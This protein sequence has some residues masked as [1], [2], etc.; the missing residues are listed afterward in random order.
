MPLTQF[1]LD[2]LQEAKTNLATVEG[3]VI[4]ARKRYAAFEAIAD[5]C[6]DAEIG[7]AIARERDDVVAAV[8]ALQATLAKF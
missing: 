4:S 6:E 2:T 8:A 3:V 5:R 1:V 7:P